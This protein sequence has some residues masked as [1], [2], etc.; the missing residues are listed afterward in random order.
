MNYAIVKIGGSQYKVA[1]GDELD[2]EKLIGEKGTKVVFDQV[3]LWVSDKK[4][5]IGQPLVKGVKVKAEILDQFKGKKIRV[6][7][8]KAKSRYRRV[9]GHR[10]LLTKI[11]IVKIGKTQ[12]AKKPLPK[13]T[14]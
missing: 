1:E 2:V 6:A 14:P 8:F 4:I 7:I 10:K 12:S 11:K 3:L 9:S 5:K 13:K